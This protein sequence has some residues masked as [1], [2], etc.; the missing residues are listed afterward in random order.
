MLP[1]REALLGPGY[2]LGEYDMWLP[3]KVT[4]KFTSRD[5]WGFNRPLPKILDE[6]QDYQQTYHSNFSI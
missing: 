5:I 4:F 6:C 1:I 3:P 2:Y